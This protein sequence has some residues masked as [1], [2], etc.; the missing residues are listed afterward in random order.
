MVKW[1]LS[2]TI[3]GQNV[4][5]CREIGIFRNGPAMQLVRWLGYICLFRNITEKI[6]F[7]NYENSFNQTN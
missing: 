6:L 7:Q 4:K 1:A 2:Q 5:K 3:T